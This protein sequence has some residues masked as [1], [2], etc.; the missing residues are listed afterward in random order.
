MVDPIRLS[1]QYHPAGNAADST[2]SPSLAMDSILCEGKDYRRYFFVVTNTQ[3]LE[4]G[5]YCELN[6]PRCITYII[7][8]GID[9]EQLDVLADAIQ[10]QY[11]NT[12]SIALN[13]SMKPEKL[14]ENH[15]DDTAGGDEEMRVSR[16]L[17]E[18]S[19]ESLPIVT[20][21]VNEELI[22][23]ISAETVSDLIH[24]LSLLH[25]I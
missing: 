8:L 17:A 10:S 2:A 20:R 7:P 23:A 9:Q 19:Y 6:L 18:S 21:Q 12:S 1:L 25:L 4:H 13:S 22:G 11:A 15:S 3:V 16:L 5:I 24:L 14:E